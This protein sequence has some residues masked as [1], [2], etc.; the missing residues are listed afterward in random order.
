MITSRFLFFALHLNNAGSFPPPLNPTE[1]ARCLQAIAAGDPAARDELIEHNLRLVVH[2][3]KKYYSNCIEQDDLISVG[4][5]GL[6]KAINTFKLEKGARLAT[7]AARCIDNEILMYF[8]N[9]K[10]TA[11][12]V[13]MSEPIDVDNEGN[14]LTLMDVISIDDTISDEIDLKMKVERLY[15]FLGKMKEGREREILILRYG[16]Y[17]NEFHTQRQVARR[18]GISRSYVSRIEKKA[19]QTMQKAMGKG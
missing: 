10:K 11:Q 17:G 19:L 8:R 4:T 18:L 3:I 14:P 12:D 9:Q 2:V 1:E 7:Y 16:L 13:S 15:E 6:I 5:I